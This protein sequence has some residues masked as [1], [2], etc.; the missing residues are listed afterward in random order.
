[1]KKKNPSLFTLFLPP[2]KH[3]STGLKISVLVIG[4]I[5]FHGRCVTYRRQAR[6][7]AQ[8]AAAGVLKVPPLPEAR[9][10]GDS[11]PPL[12]PPLPSPSESTSSAQAAPSTRTSS[13]PSSVKRTTEENDK[14]EGAE[15]AA[16]AEGAAGAGAPA[17]ASPLAATTSTEEEEEAAPGPLHPSAL[18]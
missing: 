9:A 12:L 16:A 13:T 14:E 1:M 17:A 15:E 5:R 18:S 6:T 3:A 2:A 10:R 7:G 8:T 11:T 4:G